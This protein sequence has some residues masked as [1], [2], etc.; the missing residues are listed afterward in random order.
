MAACRLF[1]SHEIEDDRREDAEKER[2]DGP[3][4]FLAH[5]HRGL[6]DPNLNDYEYCTDQRNDT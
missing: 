3:D 5:A 2:G 4:Y 1:H 6:L